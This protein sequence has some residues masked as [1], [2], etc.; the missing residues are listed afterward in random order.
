MVSSYECT[1]SII[2]QL[3]DLSSPSPE[4]FLTGG[5]MRSSVHNAACGIAAVCLSEILRFPAPSRPFAVLPDLPAGRQLGYQVVGEPL[6][7]RFPTPAGRTKGVVRSLDREPASRGRRRFRRWAGRATRGRV[8]SERDSDRLR[9]EERSSYDRAPGG[10][11]WPTGFVAMGGR[12]SFSARAVMPDGTSHNGKLPVPGG[13]PVFG[14]R[15]RAIWS[16]MRS[17]TRRFRR[18]KSRNR[19]LACPIAGMDLRSVERQG[20]R[21]LPR[22]VVSEDTALSQKIG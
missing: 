10:R 19:F 3:Y 22:R 2:V 21:S 17:G 16:W 15:T 8:A 18:E 4:F 6:R 13:E 20:A 11:M 5:R 12:R 1:R 14:V 9:A 7:M